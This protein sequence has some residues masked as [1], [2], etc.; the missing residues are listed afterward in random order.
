MTEIRYPGVMLTEVPTGAKPID[1]VTT[2][3]GDAGGRTPLEHLEQMPTVADRLRGADRSASIDNE[4]KYVSVRRYVAYLEESI[5]KG[6]QSVVFEPNDE[7]LWAN[8]RATVSDFLMTEWRSGSLVG[9]RPEQA[10]FVRC[11]RSTMTQ[12]DIDNGRL[13][14]EIGVAPTR[15]A[16]FVIVRIGAWTGSGDDK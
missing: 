1:G 6:L 14:L 4:F 12:D 10:F 16:E 11:D 3:A 13:V 2:R 9:T 5:Q 8:V 15:P 7:P